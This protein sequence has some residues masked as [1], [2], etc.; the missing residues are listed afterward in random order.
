MLNKGTLNGVKIM[1]ESTFDLL[2]TPQLN[3]FKQIHRHAPVDNVDIKPR[4]DKDV[5]FDKYDNWTLAWAY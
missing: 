2:N 5:F 3:E 1:E 4:G